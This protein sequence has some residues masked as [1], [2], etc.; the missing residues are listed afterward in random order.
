MKTIRLLQSLLIALGVFSGVVFAHGECPGTGVIDYSSMTCFFPDG[1]SPPM[2]IGVPSSGSSSGSSG[3]AR[4]QPPKVINKYGAV[5]LNKSGGSFGS[6]R[7]ASSEQEAIQGALADCGG[8]GCSI[9]S[10]YK[11]Q[12]VAM[13]WGKKNRGGM[14]FQAF[15]LQ[16]SDAENSALKKCTT[17]KAQNCQIVL[18]ECSKYR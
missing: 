13:A 12:C 7:M 4:P 11:N 6:V 18:S 16:S 14:N 10:S 17:S 5:A 1:S 2:T 15:S 9:F 3:S 8:K